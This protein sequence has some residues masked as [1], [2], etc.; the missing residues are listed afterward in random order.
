MTFFKVA[1]NYH[2]LI[3]RHTYFLYTTASFISTSIF[4]Y[5]PKKNTQSVQEKICAATL[6]FEDQEST[7]ESLKGAESEISIVL[8]CLIFLGTQGG[9]LLVIN[10]VITPISGLING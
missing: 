9:P 4:F 7:T 1:L 6:R 10:E 5:L 3:F 2:Q 8:C